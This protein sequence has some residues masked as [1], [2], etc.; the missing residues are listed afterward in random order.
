[1]EGAKREDAAASIQKLIEDI[2]LESLTR[3]LL[4]APH[5]H[6]GLSGG[7]FANVKLNRHL[8][9]NLSLDEIFIVPPMGD[10]GL[11]LG[12]GLEFLLSATACAT[13]SSCS[14]TVS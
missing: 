9:E 13:A 7:L 4:H 5:R 1:M 8:T 6:L 10:E 2:V 3:I 12:A 11:S 14:A